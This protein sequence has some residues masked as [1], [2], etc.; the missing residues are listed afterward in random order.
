MRAWGTDVRRETTDS[1]HTLRPGRFSAEAG[2][3]KLRTTQRSFV[4][5]TA[6]RPTDDGGSAECD[7]P[8]MTDLPIDDVVATSEEG[9]REQALQR[10]KK[11]REF[12]THLFAYLTINVLLWGCLLYTSPSP[13]DGLLSRMPSSA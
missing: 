7:A 1:Q 4:Q 8:R 12:H 6:W 5:R 3:G 9:L 11:R 10:V 2:S 13:R